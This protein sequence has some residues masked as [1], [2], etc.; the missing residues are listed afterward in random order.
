MVAFISL[1][2]DGHKSPQHA[3]LRVPCMCMC[4]RRRALLSCVCTCVCL[5]VCVWVYVCQRS[6]VVCACTDYYTWGC[7]HCMCA[8][9]DG[10]TQGSV[11]L[12]W[13]KQFAEVSE[14]SKGPLRHPA[15]RKQVTQ[16]TGLVLNPLQQTLYML[17]SAN[18]QTMLMISMSLVKQNV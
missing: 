3:Y 16:N 10:Q 1:Y 11:Y 15:P 18:Q 9:R 7:V 13:Q 12:G 4:M 17:I 14:G 8:E 6:V 2:Q 5:C